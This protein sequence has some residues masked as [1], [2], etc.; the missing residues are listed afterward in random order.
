[1][2]HR[3]T[4]S[5][6]LTQVPMIDVCRTNHPLRE[7]LLAAIDEV[8][9]SGRFVHGPACGAFEQRIAELSECQFAIGCASGSDALLL[10]LM[11]IG[12]TA[13]DEVIVPSFTFFATASAVQRLGARP[14]FVDILPETFN[15]DPSHVE[16]LITERTR[17]IIPVH[18]FGQCADMDAIMAIAN[19]RGLYVIEDG[20][21]SIG[22]RWNGRA[23]NSIGHL[24]CLSFYPTKNLGGLG[25]GG[26]VTTNDAG[27]AD[28]VRLLANHGMRPR[29][30]HQ[31]VGINSRLDSIQ[32]AA[33]NVKLDQLARWTAQRRAI[34]AGYERLLRQAG[35]DAHLVLPTAAPQCEHVWNQFTI[36]APDR[37][38][39]RQLLAERGVGTEIYYPVPVHRQAC[40]QELNCADMPLPQTDRASR[41]VLSLPIFPGLTDSE[42]A[43]VVEQLGEVIFGQFDYYRRAA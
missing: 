7:S 33:L 10:A 1:M 21:Q 18:L 2:I 31:C 39:L 32:A 4:A 27:L 9:S 20:C 12:I 41:E 8:L 29:Y 13:G 26:A 30:Y 5:Q 34:A 36:R 11:A 24:G 38:K 19:R 14:V 25:D 35:L 3:Q 16:E 42:Q 22:A 15:L 37:D 28:R 6:T 40:F 43:Y 23:A 17:A